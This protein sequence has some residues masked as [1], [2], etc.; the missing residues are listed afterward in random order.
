MEGRSAARGALPAWLSASA[1]F[2]IIGIEPG[3]T[4]IVVEARS[5]A[6]AVPAHFQRQE[7]FAP[8]DVSDS[9]FGLMEESLREAVA[10]SPDAELYDQPLLSTFHR[11][12]Q[13]LAEGFSSIEITNGDGVS[14]RAFITSAAIEGID[15]LIRSTP[16]PQR[17]R[18]SGKLD[19]IRHSDR[20]FTLLLDDGRS[21]KGVAE[22]VAYEQLA[23]LFGARVVISGLA[24]FR[25]SGGI[26]RIEADSIDPAGAGAEIWS[27][28]PTP[29]SRPVD[30]S[31]LQQP[32]GPR[33]GVNAIFGRW[34]RDESDD[35]T[36]EEVA[37]V[38]REIS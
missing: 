12:E 19:T 35:E 23:Q 30:V 13:V 2:D 8:V 34:P 26:L 10:G 11:F 24:V 32:Q 9:A 36:D 16:Q 20:M 6:E 15:R 18:I 37:R 27:R 31:T 28:L 22:G 38:L 21:V 29:F 1:D 14:R 33:S 17:V 4:V 5:L 7:L 3:S 25:P